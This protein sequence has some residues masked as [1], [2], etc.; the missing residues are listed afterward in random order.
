M[1]HYRSVKRVGVIGFIVFYPLYQT[2]NYFSS[3]IEFARDFGKTND[4]KI[5][6]LVS[7]ILHL[8]RLL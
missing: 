2:S 8:L 7:E 3:T 6:V 5:Y 1:K 4:N